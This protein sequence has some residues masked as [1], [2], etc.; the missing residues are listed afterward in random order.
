MIEWSARSDQ[1]L[2]K[3]EGGDR[4]VP[5][6][7]LTDL[8]VK[9]P[10]SL[11]MPTV[12]DLPDVDRPSVS[13]VVL[14]GRFGMIEGE[15]FA[16]LADHVLDLSLVRRDGVSVLKDDA[17]EAEGVI[18]YSLL[19]VGESSF[20]LD[21]GVDGAL[22]ASGEGGVQ[23]GFIVDDETEIAEMG[24]DGGHTLNPP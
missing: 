11:G 21:V 2:L 18:V 24:E 9:H 4:E 3:S 8:N 14:G 15:G 20:V 6:K 13:G 1:A 7:V 19:A 23:L 16:I 5:M 17:A 12:W 10:I 22:V